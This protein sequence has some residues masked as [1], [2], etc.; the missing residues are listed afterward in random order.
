MR[1]TG[2]ADQVD[3][4][5]AVRTLWKFCAIVEFSVSAGQ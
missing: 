4:A 5:Q 1:G 3:V 2:S